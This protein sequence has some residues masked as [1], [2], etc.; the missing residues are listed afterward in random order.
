MKNFFVKMFKF[1]GLPF[2]VL[3]LLVLFEVPQYIIEIMI[4]IWLAFIYLFVLIFLFIKF[5]PKRIKKFKGSIYDWMEE[6]NDQDENLTTQLKQMNIRYK[7]I[8]SLLAIKRVVMNTTAGDLEKLKLYKAFYQLSLKESIE[9]IYYK[10]I[11]GLISSASIF[12]IRD[13]LVKIEENGYSHLFFIILLIVFSILAFVG[14][15]N[16]NKKRVGL[17]IE[18]IDICIEEIE[19]KKKRKHVNLDGEEEF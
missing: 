5:S 6:L 19:E 9:D 14:V 10:I 3:I 4:S 17:L 7:T 1:L 18:I 16:E 13:Q 15:I 11:I 2:L 12:V 8:E